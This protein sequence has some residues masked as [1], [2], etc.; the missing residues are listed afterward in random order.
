MKI[1]SA[2][3][4]LV[5]ALLLAA[6]TPASAGIG[7]ALKDKVKKKVEKKAD[8]KTDDAIDKAADGKTGDNQSGGSEGS[9]SGGEAATDAGGGEGMKPGEGVW[10]NYDF[11]PGDRVVYFEDFSKTGVGDFPQRLQFIEGNMEVAEWRGQRW[12]R[13]TNGSRFEI[14]LPETLPQRFTLEFDYYGPTSTNTISIFDGTDQQE[15]N[16][17]L[18]FFWYLA[19]GLGRRGN[20]VASLELPARA[21]EKIA[22]CR[23]MGDGKYVKVY[24][25]ETRVANVPNSTFARSNSLP[26]QI[27]ADANNPLMIANIRIAEGGKKI[28]YDQLM[29]D[30]KVVT[31][32]ILFASGS[33]VIDPESTPT[34]K[35]I[36]TML[37]DHA[38]LKLSI[39]GHT[40]NVGDDA[41]NLDLSKRRAAAVKTYLIEKYSIG[42]DRLS[43]EGYGETKPVGTN[44]TPEGRQNNRRV[45]LIK[46]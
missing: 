29:A 14:P 45:E 12:L 33:D 26:V 22:H 41:S 27:W 28:L 2:I 10:V 23:V 24:V 18:T 38:D 32:G 43:T 35:E 21:K 6:T 39:E 17:Q 5:C 30:G 3:C 19:C 42:A 37:K 8:E 7:G 16:N 25:N 9:A 40:D 13:A 1:Y 4:I 20:F 36:G 46:L 31:Q 34:L 44:D 11:I 15:D